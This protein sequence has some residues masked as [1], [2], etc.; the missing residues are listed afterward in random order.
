MNPTPARI[1]KLA[2]FTL[3]LFCL[4]AAC[5]QPPPVFVTQPQ[6]MIVS[7]GSTVTLAGEVEGDEPMGFRWRRSSI[8][9]L[10]MKTNCDRL[11]GQVP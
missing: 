8:T 4:A 3:L 6:G 10:P 11:D 5:A 2:A 9:L 7:P 1:H